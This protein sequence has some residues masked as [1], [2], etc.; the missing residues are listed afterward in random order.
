MQQMSMQ[1]LPPWATYAF[2]YQNVDYHAVCHFVA[3]QHVPQG[4]PESG[5][6]RE[7]SSTQ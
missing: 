3:V 2:N 7:K 6:L 4:H 1:T 5:A